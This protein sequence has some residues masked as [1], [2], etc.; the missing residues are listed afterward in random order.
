MSVGKAFG[1]ILLYG[2]GCLHHLIDC[3]ITIFGEEALAE[4][5]GELHK[6]ITLPVKVQF[7]IDCCF[8]HNARSAV[9]VTL[10]I[11]VLGIRHN[12][13]YYI[14]HCSSF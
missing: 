7:S 14:K 2:T 9:I 12:N 5:L 1:Y 13:L 11:N 6:H 3:A 10:Q 4:S 8:P